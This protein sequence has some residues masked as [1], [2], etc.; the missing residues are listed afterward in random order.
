MH[1]DSKLVKIYERILLTTC[2]SSECLIYVK[3]SFLNLHIA[4][5]VHN[6][7]GNIMYSK[8]S[9]EYCFEVLEY[10]PFKL[11]ERDNLFVFQ[12]K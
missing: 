12:S 10:N 4:I 3:G 7:V 6:K 8:T 11:G 2:L 1:Y 9:I 5:S